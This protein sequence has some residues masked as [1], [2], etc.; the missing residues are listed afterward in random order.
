MWLPIEYWAV[1]T[2]IATTV[3]SLLVLIVG[4]ILYTCM[5]LLSDRAELK[6]IC[7]GAEL[8]LCEA[9]RV[10]IHGCSGDLSPSALH[11][12]LAFLNKSSAEESISVT[13][14]HE[15]FALWVMES[16]K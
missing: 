6:E 2:L 16:A 5:S 12:F 15:I 9:F 13:Q 10:R 8:V 14:L 3:A 4:R 11:K 7:P 1:S